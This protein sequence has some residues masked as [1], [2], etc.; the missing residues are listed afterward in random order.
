MAR[1]LG[2][3][4]LDQRRQRAADRV[5]DIDRVHGRLQHVQILDRQAR[6]QLGRLP[7]RDLRAQNVFERV[8][9]RKTLRHERQERDPVDERDK[10]LV[11]QDVGEV[12][13]AGHQRA[14]DAPAGRLRPF[15]QL[16]FVQDVQRRTQQHVASVEDLVEE[17]VDRAQDALVGEVLRT[18]GVHQRLE[19]DRTDE[20]GLHGALRELAREQAGLPRVLRDDAPED[21]RRQLA[22]GGS[23]WPRD[24]H[25]L[26]RQQRQRDL[27]EDVLALDEGALQLAEERHE[28]I[29][30][31]T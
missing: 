6:L 4:P 23:R 25:V 27:L 7:S 15:L 20:I 21:A 24:Q 9:R 5:V 2:V 1:Q 18:A 26:A 22:L 17:R 13:V 29:A 3:E 12:A 28:A 10:A 14:L 16:A 30:R 8:R 19:V 11:V 31:L